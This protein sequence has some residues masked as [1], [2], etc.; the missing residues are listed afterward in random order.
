M[1]RTLNPSSMP[2][3][4]GAGRPQDD[5]GPT[6]AA[7]PQR[8]ERSSSTLSISP[9]DYRSVRSSPSP[10]SEHDE[11][12][13]RF[14]ARGSPAARPIGDEQQRRP[15]PSIRQVNEGRG[16][17]ANMDNRQTR[18]HSQLGTLDGFP[19]GVDILHSTP[20]P[21][22]MRGSGA[23]AF[24]LQHQKSREPMNTPPLPVGGGGSSGNANN[25][26]SSFPF[27]SSSPVSSLDSASVFASN[28]STFEAQ[29]K[30]S[31]MIRDILDRL[32]RCEFT[33]REIQRDIGEM[34]RKVNLLVDRS[35]NTPQPSMSLNNGMPE[36]K[37][38]FA[39]NNPSIISP[40]LAGPRP[41][42]GGVAPNQQGPND[43]ISSI[44]QRLNTL[45]SSVGQ[46]L[47]LQTQQL[48]T[49]TPGLSNQS[50]LNPGMLG[51]PSTPDIAPNQVLSSGSL[52]QNNPMMNAGLPSRPSIAQARL[53]NLPNP[54]MRTWSTGNLDLPPRP[55]DSVIRQ[56]NAGD[57]LL[58]PKRRSVSGLQ[59]RDSS[60]VS[61]CPGIL[62]VLL[63][64]MICRSSTRTV[65]GL[66]EA[67]SGRARCCQNGSSCRSRQSC[68]GL[69]PN[70]GEWPTGSV[71]PP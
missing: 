36:F 15:S 58:G 59:R 70:L 22:E 66:R 8:P 54:P 32:V 46:L 5:G 47:A 38:P 50:P 17:F 6:F 35:L 41:S 20:A 64:T 9:S 4:P 18:E 60:G 23:A 34:H 3:F 26:P 27:S 68:C 2:F 31:P 7:R 62:H 14:S 24:F 39:P 11:N 53:A 71:L 30:A 61:I 33:T 63:L 1:A 29:L 48:Q 45:T 55:T 56:S 65:N 44:S 67:L 16:S 51:N 19:E 43:D 49:S 21:D 12:Q 37:D 10:P 52:M 13:Q 69:S 40:P 28:E 42:F 57:S 25:G